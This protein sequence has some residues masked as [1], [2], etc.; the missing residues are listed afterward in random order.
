MQAIL[1]FNMNPFS[2]S[3]DS[4]KMRLTRS[5][6]P[7]AEMM[8]YGDDNERLPEGRR[9]DQVTSPHTNDVI[10]GRG[11]RFAWHSGNNEFQELVRNNIP[12]YD[13][14]KR[15]NDKTRVVQEIFEAVASKGRFL[16]KDEGTGLYEVVEDHIAKEKISQAIRYKK[17]RSINAGKTGKRTGSPLLASAARKQ[18]RMD[19][20]MKSSLQ[21]RGSP[22]QDEDAVGESTHLTLPV[23]PMPSLAMAQTHFGTQEAL[24]AVEPMKSTQHSTQPARMLDSFQG[25]SHLAKSGH[26]KRTPRIEDNLPQGGADSN[27]ASLRGPV[28][29]SVAS[30]QRPVLD[31]DLFDDDTLLNVLGPKD[32]VKWPDVSLFGALL[33]F[34]MPLQEFHLK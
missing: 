25:A 22:S 5:P 1:C 4:S 27:L 3:N 18:H 8:D 14:A 9:G 21:R 16:K 32:Q 33:S 13:A 30:E 11:F 24:R 15:K 10:L 19:P 28:L 23:P 29:P 17:R 31:E 2:P 26:R 7:S 20:S 34:D 6:G 12:R